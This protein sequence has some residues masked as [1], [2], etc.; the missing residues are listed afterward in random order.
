MRLFVRW[1]KWTNEWNSNWISFLCWR[2]DASRDIHSHWAFNWCL[3]GAF[4]PVVFGCHLS[5]GAMSKLGNMPMELI[6]PESFHN[7]AITNRYQQLQPLFINSNIELSSFAVSLPLSLSLSFAPTIEQFL[8]ALQNHEHF[9][10]ISLNDVI[11]LELRRKFRAE[12]N[13]F[14]STRAKEKIVQGFEKRRKNS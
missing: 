5:F 4:L 8:L 1:R 3:T 9:I 10:F 14:A 11:D 12:R 13:S 2:C 6:K 7:G